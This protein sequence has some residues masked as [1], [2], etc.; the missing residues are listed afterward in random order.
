ML[1]SIFLI[2]TVLCCAVLGTLQFIHIFQL[3]SYKPKEQIK[4][5]KKYFSRLMPCMLIFVYLLICGIL[6][7][8]S[9]LFTIPAIII[10][11]FLKTKKAKKPLV[12]T[13]RV[14][15]MLVTN[16]L[17]YAVLCVLIFVIEAKFKFIVTAFTCGLVPLIVLLANLI[18]KPIELSIN[19]YYIND[20]K[21][22]LKSN[23]NLKIIGVTGSFGKTSVKFYLNTLLRAKFNVL[24]TPESY[25]T[26]LGI[27]KTIRTKLRATDQIFI[28]EMGARNVGDIRE[29]C[30]IVHPQHGVI[31]TV[32]EQHLETF[33]TLENIQKTK[34]ELADSL[35]EDGMLFVNG[36]CDAI[37]N[38]NHNKL[39]NA[40]T[41]GL[42]Q[43]ND[44]QAYD[45]KISERGSEFKVRL[46]TG[47]VCEYTTKLIGEHNVINIVGAIAIS[48]KMG[49]PL[50]K[51]R[52]QV[53][54]LECVPHRLELINRGGIIMVDDAYNSNPSGCK[55]ALETIQY[56]DGMKI[57]VTPGMVELG[58]LQEKL[59]YEFGVL[60]AKMCDFIVLVGEKQTQPIFDGVKSSGFEMS[61]C[62][63]AEDLNDA[64]KKVYSISTDKKKI[65]LLEN[66]LPD[67]Y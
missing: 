6:K 59:N 50:E 58:Q 55:A 1:T 54:K 65:V 56:F 35:P 10:S 57:L 27:V 53:R 12:F 15:R 5:Y 25:N 64:L 28:C 38:F 13:P 9:F 30:D 33:K 19:R 49:I 36:D 66:D 40:V 21:K 44:Y 22:M 24:M 46:K 4:W 20:A 47:E 29:I 11:L 41:Y 34:F 16:G 26:P 39:E 18:N 7:A 52:P 14:K 45:L 8:K 31:T 51:L 62:Y 61:N 17:I 23:P 32:G 63:V 2:L 43:G 3:N 42:S 37:R 48:H 67:N 60:S